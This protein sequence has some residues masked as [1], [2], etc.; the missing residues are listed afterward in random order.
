MNFFHKVINQ[1]RRVVGLSPHTSSS[2]PAEPKRR[3]GRPK[4][5]ETEEEQQQAHRKIDTESH[6]NARKR[7]KEAEA[8][9]AR[10]KAAQIRERFACD[11]NGN[12]LKYSNGRRI[13]REDVEEVQ[14][15]VNSAPVAPAAPA[16]PAPSPVIV[17]QVI[18]ESKPGPEPTHNAEK[19]AEWWMYRGKLNF[20]PDR[21]QCF[22][23]N[24]E[25]NLAAASS[26]GQL[27]VTI[28][29]W[30]SNYDEEFSTLTK[31][32]VV[33]N[34][35]DGDWLKSLLGASPATQA[36]MRLFVGDI[37]SLFEMK[38]DT[39]IAI[40]HKQPVT[41]DGFYREYFKAMPQ[42]AEQVKALLQPPPK[43]P[44]I[45]TPVPSPFFGGGGY[46]TSGWNP[47][48]PPLDPNKNDGSNFCS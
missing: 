19:L 7:R 5:Y 8:E 10:K 20:E 22:L 18:V 38:R 1:A 45:N 34:R 42:N 31:I 16:A 17:Q 30:D 23:V 14:P 13:S 9:E 24:G 48:L 11:A 15:V 36:K 27:A 4:K 28:P 32:W 25:A 46:R 2:E 44:V 39:D 43:P 26:K 3:G 41:V 33:V 47:E 35:S 29:R 6:A 37:Q 12:P 21:T 40:L